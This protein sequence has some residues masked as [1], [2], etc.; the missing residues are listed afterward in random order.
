MRRVSQGFL[1]L[2][3]GY[4]AVFVIIPAHHTHSGECG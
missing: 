4:A 3:R 2:L 1:P